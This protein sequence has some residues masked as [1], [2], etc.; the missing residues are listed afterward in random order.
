MLTGKNVILLIAMVL[1]LAFSS[2]GWA[3]ASIDADFS[4]S[5]GT[6]VAA[7][8]QQIRI[9]DIVVD[10]T[11]PATGMRTYGSFDVIFEWNPET[12]MMVPVGIANCQSGELRVQVSCAI[13]GEP[14]ENAVVSVSTQ[15]LS[16]DE[17]GIVR[18]YSLPGKQTRVLVSA[19]GYVT[20]AV[21]VEMNCGLYPLS[22]QLMP[23]TD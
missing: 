13:T 18:F 5:D 21:D 15:D 11:D 8:V 7:S 14:I 3:N 22:I 9:N 23:V 16:S 10:Y 12:Y 2:P 6:P 20:T 19:S 17:D 1:G 4:A